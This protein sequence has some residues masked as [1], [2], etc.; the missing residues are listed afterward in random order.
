MDSTRLPATT[1]PDTADVAVDNNQLPVTRLLLHTADLAEDNNQQPV[2]AARYSADVA[3]D[4][5]HLAATGSLYP[6]ADN[7]YRKVRGSLDLVYKAEEDN[8]HQ[9]VSL[10]PE[11]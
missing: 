2:T 6:S 8:N 10:R 9:A 7:N 5:N 1:P 3:V 11:S 4:N